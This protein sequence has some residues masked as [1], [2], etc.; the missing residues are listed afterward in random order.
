M[1]Y[2]DWRPVSADAIKPKHVLSCY[3]DLKNSSDYLIFEEKLESVFGKN[4]YAAQYIGDHIESFIYSIRIDGIFI[5][6]FIPRDASDPELE[7]VSRQLTYLIKCLTGH[8]HNFDEQPYLSRSDFHS[9]HTIAVH[10]PVRVGTVSGD[11]ARIDKFENNEGFD[12]KD[13]EYSKMGLEG[14]CSEQNLPRILS[15]DNFEKYGEP[16][17]LSIR[18]N[19]AESF[20]RASRLVSKVSREWHPLA[21]FPAVLYLLSAHTISLTVSSIINQNNVLG[22]GWGYFIIVFL[23]L[24]FSYVVVSFFRD[25]ARILVGWILIYPKSILADQIEQMKKNKSVV[26]AS[27]Y[28]N[29]KLSPFFRFFVYSPSSINKFFIFTF[30]SVTLFYFYEMTESHHWLFGL[31]NVEESFDIVFISSGELYDYYFRVIFLSMIM[32]ATIFYARLKNHRYRREKIVAWE[33]CYGYMVYA[34]IFDVVSKRCIGETVVS[35]ASS[36]TNAK[37]LALF[38]LKKEKNKQLLDYIA[39]SCVIIV[40]MF[41]IYLD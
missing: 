30:Y 38:Y 35:S 32:C 25:V 20:D 19:Y 39:Y 34:S 4:T 15:S 9:K 27:K 3:Y 23:V 18:R 41:L 33:K 17:V 14:L 22:E 31:N 8:V 12:C 5:F 10:S 26:G 7:R 24:I 16:A 6:A 11:I 2:I 36:F 28:F 21:I 13:L 40:I 1:I 29:Q 37:E